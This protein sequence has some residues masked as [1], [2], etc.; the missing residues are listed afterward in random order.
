MNISQSDNGV[1]EVK[2]MNIIDKIR[3]SL[4]SFCLDSCPKSPCPCFTA[5]EKYMEKNCVTLSE[6]REIAL[7]LESDRSNKRTL[8]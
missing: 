7:Y 6:R 3:E 2:A 1:S 8:G 5:C 4:K